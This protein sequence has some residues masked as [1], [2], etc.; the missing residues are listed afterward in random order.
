MNRRTLLTQ[1]GITLAGGLLLPH[2]LKAQFPVTTGYPALNTTIVNS[3]QSNVLALYRASEAHTASAATIQ[4]AATSFSTLFSHFA[5]TGYNPVYQ[6]NIISGI[7]SRLASGINDGPRIAARLASVGIF[8]TA[9][10]IANNY[11]VA[12]YRPTMNQLIAVLNA[13][14]IT[15]IWSKFNLDLHEAVLRAE[16]TNNHTISGDSMPRTSLRTIT[17]EPPHLQLE[18]GCGLDGLVV[19][20]LAIFS[21]PPIDI[22]MGALGLTYGV[23]DYFKLC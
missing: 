23:L 5:A 18:P 15:Y 14:T 6:R 3:A 4:A 21:P 9:A 22:M 11:N 7:Q 20:V 2:L 13:D 17:I 16:S 1:S 8:L 10:Q 19:S 12:E